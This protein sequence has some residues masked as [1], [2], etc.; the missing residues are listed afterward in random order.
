MTVVL[1]DI[2]ELAQ[3]PIE[4]NRAHLDGDRVGYYLTHLDQA[5]PVVV[6]DT[7]DE[8]LLADGYHRVAAAQQ[9]GRGAIRAR[10]RSGTRQDALA[11]AV[12]LGMAQR[13]LTADEVREA[14]RRRGDTTAP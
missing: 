4:G 14:I 11:F 10:V 7:G 1:L 5:P 13:G 6:F 12:G 3:A 8:L 9:L 2:A